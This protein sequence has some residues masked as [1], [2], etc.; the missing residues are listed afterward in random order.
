MQIRKSIQIP[1]IVALGMLLAWSF[2]NVPVST[3]PVTPPPAPAPAPAP[4]SPEIILPV[5]VTPDPAVDPI[6]DPT[7]EIE[8]QPRK[9]LFRRDR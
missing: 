3:V 2:Y 6:P 5:K 9:R 4:C 7:P 1:I 8:V